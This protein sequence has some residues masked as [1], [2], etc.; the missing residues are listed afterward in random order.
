MD[1][2]ITWLLQQSPVIVVMGVVIYWLA[3]QLKKANEDKD[4]L[5]KDVVKLTTIWE[6][7]YQNEGN[8]EDKIIEL[9]TEIKA[10]VSR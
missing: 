2:I 8:K 10:I 3:A 9:L 1:D 5:S 6:E 4:N 7:K